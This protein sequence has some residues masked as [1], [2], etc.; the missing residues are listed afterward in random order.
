MQL[1]DY[2]VSVVEGEEVNGGYVLLEHNTKYSI[3]L[4]NN[5]NTDCDAEI[6]I[7]GVSVGIF[8]V[9]SKK[10]VT[11]ER[12]ATENGC[13]TFLKFESEEG[14]QAQ[15][16][17]NEELGLV[18]VTFKPEKEITYDSKGVPVGGYKSAAQRILG[19]SRSEEVSVSAGGTGLFGRSSQ[20]F[21]NVSPL[22][23]DQE[24][25][26]KINLRLICKEKDKIR[27]LGGKT[28]D[29]PPSLFSSFKEASTHAK[30]KK[31]GSV[32][33]NGDGEGFFWRP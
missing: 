30:I 29:I 20:E 14:V 17:K 8:R 32:I 13:F 23:Y 9:S 4:N 5:K 21:K 25:I 12:P 1:D 31:I 26:I 3:N 11:I 24:N 28:T 6:Q 10:S 19:S 27:P 15:L 22:S 16:E 2:E 7:D 18:S 33:K